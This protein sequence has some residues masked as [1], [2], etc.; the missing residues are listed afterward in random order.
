MGR[1]NNCDSPI[2]IGKG[3]DDGEGGGKWISLIERVNEVNWSD[4]ADDVFANKQDDPLHWMNKYIQD[5]VNHSPSMPGLFS[6]P[7]Q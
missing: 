7:T 3:E 4:S 1:A 2:T 5:P 6:P